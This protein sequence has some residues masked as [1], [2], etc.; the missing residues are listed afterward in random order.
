MSQPFHEKWHAAQVQN[1]SRLALGIAPRLAKMPLPIAR[2]DDPF[3]PFGRAIIEVT[4]DLVCAYVFD[5][6]SYLALGAAGARALERTIP[7]V[8][9][10]I[11]TILHGPFVTADYAQA[12][13]ENA[14]SADAVTLMTSD[15]DVIA[16]Y[17]ENPVHGVFVQQSSAYLNR[18]NVG[19]YS[20]DQLT[21]HG[22]R[23]LWITEPILYASGKDDFQ[24]TARQQAEKFRSGNGV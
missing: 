10:H 7:L 24:E 16:A 2:Y 1:Q 12:A 11:P 21:M 15:P 18:F 8:P 22:S 17:L 9:R 4:S 23:A 3:L 14:F 13:F 6:A 20:A 5:L 19:T